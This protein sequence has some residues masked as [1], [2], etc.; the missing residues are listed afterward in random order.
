MQIAHHLGATVT[1]VAGVAKHD[2]LRGLGAVRTVDYTDPAALAALAD[3]PVDV[4]LDL[5]GR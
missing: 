5:I 4:A 1:A 2:W 3:Q